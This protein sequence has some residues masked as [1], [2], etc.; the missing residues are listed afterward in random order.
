MSTQTDEQHVR[1][2]IDAAMSGTRPPVDLSATA[3]ARGRRLRTRRRIGV[4]GVA[5]AASVLA[6]VAVPWAFGSD[7]DRAI[8]S[9]RLTASEP[10][11]P[12]P[13]QPPGWWDMPATEMVATVEA[14]LPDA[15]VVTSPG[16][17][18]ADTPEGGPATGW[19]NAELTGPAGP[20]R[21]NVIL[22]PTWTRT[23]TLTP[24]P[25][26]G[27]STPSSS[28]DPTGGPVGGEDGLSAEE[29]LGLVR[30]RSGGATTDGE[31]DRT[32]C[33]EVFTGHTEC[34][35]IR[36]EDGAIVGRRLTNR[37]GAVVMTEVVLVRDGGTIYAASVNSL[38]D[39]PG[40]GSPT[41]A[42]RPP[43]TLDQLE[44]L[45]RNDAWVSYEP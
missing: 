3:L 9:S 22:S 11:A 19:I 15:V 31:P 25:G 24:Q 10:P 37:S 4:A 41:S 30:S 33:D 2:V 23:T 27:G 32:S 20:G 8:D 34:E 12:Q 13:Q 36:D 40:A 45:V 17:L 44:A 43:L 14:I 35:Q 1:E 5:V 18:E 16:P 38:D 39:K 7:D 21:L 26:A 6:A 42:A 28:T 29:A